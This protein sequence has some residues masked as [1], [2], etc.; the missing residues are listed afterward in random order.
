LCST[1][2]RRSSRALARSGELAVLQALL[3]AGAKAS[4]RDND[5]DT[6]IHYASAQGHA[7]CIKALAA[8]PGGCDLEAVDND[9]E[10]P[11]D[12]AARQAP[13]S[14]GRLHAQPCAHALRRLR[15]ARIRTVLRTLIADAEKAAASGSEG[16]EEGGEWEECSG[17]EDGDDDAAEKLAALKVDDKK[18]DKA[19][20]KSASAGAKK[21]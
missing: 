14:A 11:M 17:E 6:P 4:V 20:A 12:V 5:G 10:T 19:P 3:K 15:S 16:G 1:T 9:G 21:K 2:L 7:D 8:A 18:A 13:C